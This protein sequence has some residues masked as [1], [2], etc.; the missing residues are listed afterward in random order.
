MKSKLLLLLLLLP[1]TVFCQDIV[2]T[3][4]PTPLTALKYAN[5]KLI[6]PIEIGMELSARSVPVRGDTLTIP[7]TVFLSS[8]GL[9]A[10]LMLTPA[11][12]GLVTYEVAAPTV[13]FT[14]DTTSRKV[15]VYVIIPD[16]LNI[17]SNK[18]IVL[19]VIVN[20]LQ[21]STKNLFIEPAN[22]LIYSLKQYDTIPSVRLDHV[23]KVESADNI[24]T[25][26]GYK[27]RGFTKRKVLLEKN[28]VLA[29]SEPNYIFVAG[30][31]NSAPFSLVAVPFKIRPRVKVTLNKTGT[32]VD[33]AFGAETMSGISNLG[34]NIDLI[35]R[36]TDRYFASGKKATHKRG[37]GLII[38]PGVEELSAS[39]IKDTS[40]MGDKKSKQLYI[41]VG[42][43][44]FYS[45]NGITFFVVPAA[46]DWAP[47]NLGKQWIYNKR[48]WWGFGIG[49]SPTIFTQIFNK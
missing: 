15:R 1:V 49:V 32:S 6:M 34:I 2:V 20:N 41:S 42:I 36:T 16:T 43:S 26:S 27:N 46:I 31:L 7:F 48:F 11:E 9:P 40:L 39:V 23:S 35:K 22:D 21:A 8:N 30:Y 25:V 45:Y 4:S 37:L 14:S 33:T 19:Q 13:T 47:S 3:I 28:Q 38:T 17:V 18:A 44:A 24:L 10:S 5:E 12:F 29:I